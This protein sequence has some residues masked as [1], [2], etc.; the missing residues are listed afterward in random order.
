[1]GVGPLW[2]LASAQ[3]ERIRV[4]W[5]SDNLIRARRKVDVWRALWAPPS[6]G[7]PGL[8]DE[9]RDW[10]W[11]VLP[12]DEGT[13]SPTDHKGLPQAMLRTSLVRSLQGP[14]CPQGW[15]LY[16]KQNDAWH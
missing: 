13:R 9:T 15:F 7:R 5:K 12:S 6:A 10:A 2:R 8:E 16:A 4:S 14:S 11:R 3:S 1:K